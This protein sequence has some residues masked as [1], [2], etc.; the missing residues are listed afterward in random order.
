MSVLECSLAAWK[1]E[2]L[3]TEMELYSQPIHCLEDGSYDPLQCD[4]TNWCRCL[5]T[6]SNVPDSDRVFEINIKKDN[7]KCCKHM[8]F[9]EQVFTVK[10]FVGCGQLFVLFS[11]NHHHHHLFTFNRSLFGNNMPLDVEI[12]MHIIINC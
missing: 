8:Y 6:G 4:D 5:Q 1:A 11:I 9:N 2:Q 7:P 12:V 10:E 3:A